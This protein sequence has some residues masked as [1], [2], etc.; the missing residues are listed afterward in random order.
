[1]LK[2]N[3]DLA[4]DILW[5][6]S[7]MLCYGKELAKW[8]GHCGKTCLPGLAQPQ[9]G[10]LCPFA[11]AAHSLTLIWILYGIPTLL[12]LKPPALVETKTIPKVDAIHGYR[13]SL[14]G[15]VVHARRPR[16]FEPMTRQHCTRSH[17]MGHS[18]TS[19]TQK[20]LLRPV[21]RQ[22][23]KIFLFWWYQ[24]QSWYHGYGTNT[25]MN[26][27][28]KSLLPLAKVVLA[29]I[30]PTKRVSLTDWL[31]DHSCRGIP[32]LTVIHWHLEHLSRVATNKLMHWCASRWDG[33]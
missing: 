31:L 33:Y 28:V 22:R 17:V 12:H 8:F 19:H 2:K 9:N 29:K 25:E 1:M 27:I 7:N 4:F 23:S 30:I 21:V 14:H 6:H 18:T 32:K 24:R 10:S 15:F 26:G 11:I 13:I 20:L 5:I 16:S 3:T